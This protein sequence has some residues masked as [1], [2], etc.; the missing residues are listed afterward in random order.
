VTQDARSFPRE[1]GEAIE[2]I[3]KIETIG[4]F[5]AGERV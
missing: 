3:E 5:V 2:T 1:E 4:K